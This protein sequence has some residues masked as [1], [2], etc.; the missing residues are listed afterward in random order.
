[1]VLAFLRRLGLAHFTSAHQ[2]YM[3]MIATAQKMRNFMA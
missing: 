2:Q 3:R 1:V